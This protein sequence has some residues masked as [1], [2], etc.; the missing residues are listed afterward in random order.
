MTE[1]Q[2][3]IDDFQLQLEVARLQASEKRFADAYQT[4]AVAYDNLLQ[5]HEEAIEEVLE[6]R[7]KLR[8]HLR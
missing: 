5:Q 6:L 7:K 3:P 4:L 8:N 1:N 2:D